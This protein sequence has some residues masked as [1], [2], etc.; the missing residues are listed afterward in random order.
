MVRQMVQK[1]APLGS[2]AIPMALVPVQMT[3]AD[4]SIL[5]HSIV[6]LADDMETLLR[7][8]LC[9]QFI[10]LNLSLGLQL[11][12]DLAHLETE[13]SNGYLRQGCGCNLCLRHHRE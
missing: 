10:L 5:E 7:S 12:S 11:L 6:K 9:L 1:V 8:L 3:M 4:C 13:L 2:F